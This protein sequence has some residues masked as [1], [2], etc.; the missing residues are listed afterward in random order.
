M[1]LSAFVLEA[2][3][4]ACCGV[5]ILQGAPAA[6]VY[7]S[8]IVFVL[9]TTISRPLHNV[10]M[11]LVVKRPDELTAANVATTWSEGLGAVAGPALAGATISLDGPGLACAV[12]ALLACA[13]PLLGRVRPLRVAAE[14]R[15]LDH[16][17]GHGLARADFQTVLDR[18]GKGLSHEG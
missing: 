1:L 7:A 16:L 2:V 10:L 15:P 8:A 14:K 17:C 12:L 3:S 6:L 5:A 18:F 9:G 11:P 4:L 13:M